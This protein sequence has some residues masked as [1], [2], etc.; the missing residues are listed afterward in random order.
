MAFVITRHFGENIV[1]EHSDPVLFSRY[2]LP[3][4][5]ETFDALNLPSDMYVL[6]VTY[7]Q[8]Q[9]GGG[10]DTQ[11][12][13][14]GTIEPNETIK[15]AAKR[16]LV[17]E[18]HFAAERNSYMKKIN[19]V[20]NTTWYSCEV[21]N[22]KFVENPNEIN[23]RRL[24]DFFKS[25]SNFCHNLFDRFRSTQKKRKNKIACIVYGTREEMETL[26]RSFKGF[27]STKTHNND[28]IVGLACLSVE[29]AKK[30]IDVVLTTKSKELLLFSF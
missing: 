9:K 14:T 21:K 5:K 23:Q 15:H 29:N 8:D 19:K 17:E 24:G 4:T 18:T 13:I 28:D 30:V 12:F 26:M 3:G 11:I 6:C 22:L 16:E 20:K 25:A 27:D 1:V 2:L 7:K 10:G